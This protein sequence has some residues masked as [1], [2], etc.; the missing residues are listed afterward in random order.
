MAVHERTVSNHEKLVWPGSPLP[1]HFVPI[2]TGPDY[3]TSS[4]TVGLEATGRRLMVTPHPKC[5]K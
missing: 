4:L 2:G 5:R 1:V 3:Y